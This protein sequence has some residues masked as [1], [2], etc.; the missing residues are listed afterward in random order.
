MY[1]SFSSAAST[2]VVCLSAISVSIFYLS[3]VVRH[4]RSVARSIIAFGA[5]LQDFGGS[6]IR[7]YFST[8]FL[9]P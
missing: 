6:D 4:R 1:L 2:T 5:I 7:K 3:V 9:K 8:V